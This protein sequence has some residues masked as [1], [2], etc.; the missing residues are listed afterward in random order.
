M[1]QSRTIKIYPIIVLEVYLSYDV[2]IYI[3]PIVLVVV[4]SYVISHFFCII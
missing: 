4:S 3:N 2:E 1:I